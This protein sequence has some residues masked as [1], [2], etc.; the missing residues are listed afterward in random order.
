MW[1][2]AI[3]LQ[4]FRKLRFTEN[5]SFPKLAISCGNLK[6]KYFYWNWFV[7]GVT[8]LY[9]HWGLGHVRPESVREHTQK[10]KNEK[11]TKLHCMVGVVRL[12][13]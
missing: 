8:H 7:G 13:L 1:T 3:E 10:K 5:T 6:A 2:N 11:I 9:C 4:F 12:G